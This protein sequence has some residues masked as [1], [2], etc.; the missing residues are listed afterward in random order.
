M[1]NERRIKHLQER[2]QRHAPIMDDDNID[3]DYTK[4][5]PRLA[6]DPSNGEPWQQFQQD[7]WDIQ[8]LTKEEVTLYQAVA[9]YK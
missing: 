6:N 9:S 2:L 1:K 5:K 8:P 4:P 7:L 3:V